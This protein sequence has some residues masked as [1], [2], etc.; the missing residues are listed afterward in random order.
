MSGTPLEYEHRS[1]VRRRKRTARVAF[2]LLAVVLI[3]LGIA[4][5]PAVWRQV[6]TLY[7]QHRCMI[8]SPPS[9]TLAVRWEWLLTG[10]MNLTECA[11]PPP[12]PVIPLFHAIF[13]AKT[14]T[15]LLSH[16]MERPDGTER[17]VIVCDSGV[18]RTDSG[19]VPQLDWVVIAPGRGLTGPRPTGTSQ[20]GVHDHAAW[21]SSTIE[22]DY[23]SLDPSDSS[24]F[25]I[26]M[27]ADDKR[28]VTVD[29]WLRDDDT[30]LLEF[31]SPVPIPKP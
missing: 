4:R 28:R 17:L 29:G 5:G 10:K 6:Q 25:T 24:H 22:M 14:G 12:P 23:A 9:G 3:S 20:Y 26:A 18:F 2:G 15:V 19:F 16:A 31:R 7:W 27:T 13:I 30:V 1:I 8:F 21:W 11:I